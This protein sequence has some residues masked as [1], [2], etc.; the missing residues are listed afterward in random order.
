[1]AKIRVLVAEDSLTVRKRLVEVLAADAG[2]EVVGEAEDGRQAIELCQRLRPDV[3]TVDMMMPALS[4]LAVTEYVM[5]YCPTP[6]LIVSAS[7]NRGEVFKTYEALTA[8]AVDVLDKPTGAEDDWEQRFIATVKL[9]SRIKVITHSRARRSLRDGVTPMSVSAGG[10]TGAARLVAIGA[11]TGGPAAIVEVLRSLPRDFPLP[12][13]FVLHIGQPF[14]NDFADWLDGQS[15]LRVANATDGELLPPPGK[16]RVMM[17]IPD[18]HLVLRGGRLRLTDTP[19]RHSCRPSVDELFES[20]AAEMGAATIACLLT[21]MGRDGAR[22]LLALRQSGGRTIA[23]DE[24]SSAVWGMPGEAVA[25]GAAESVL[26]LSQI[27]A[28]LM[29]LAARPAAE[30][31]G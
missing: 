30:G 12:I 9:V 5:A 15:P 1:M 14:G 10:R 19:E 13:L 4:G 26:P 28:G 2:L 20:L 7:V 17:A 18:R 6:I 21:G 22:G 25:L 24:A 27:G 3:L 23:Q 16:G 11:S 29:A 8:G 31:E